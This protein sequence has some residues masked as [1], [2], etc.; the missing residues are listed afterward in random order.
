MGRNTMFTTA[1]LLAALLA[2]AVS[3]GVARA[4]YPERAITIFACFPVGGGNDLPCASSQRRFRKFRKPVIVEIAAAP[5]DTRHRGGRPHGRRRLSLLGCSSAFNVN[6]SLYANASYDPFKD[7]VPVIVL[8]RRRTLRVPNIEIQDHERVHCVGQ[9]NPGKLNWTVRAPAP[10]RNWREKSSRPAPESKW[11]TFLHRLRPRQ[12]RGDGQPGRHVHRE[13]CLCFTAAQQRQSAHDRRHLQDRYADL[14][15]V[16][17]LDEVGIKDAETD[18]FQAILRRPEAEGRCR[19][20]GQEIAIILARPTS[21]KIPEHRAAGGGGRPR[22]I[23]RAH[24]PR[25]TDV[26][27]SH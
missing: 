20:A 6:P 12:Q 3:S 10:R 25:S 21:G 19:S 13:L 27:G 2:V 24:R 5:A 22:R 4:E 16:P 15:D 9:A 17:T 11:C 18:T 7:F 8:G 14:P 23:S 1:R 26:Q